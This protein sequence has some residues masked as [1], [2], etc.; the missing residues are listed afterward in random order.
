MKTATVT[1]RQLR[2]AISRIVRID[3]GEIYIRL[4]AWEYSLVSANNLVNERKRMIRALARDI[5]FNLGFGKPS[6]NLERVQKGLPMIIPSRKA[7]AKMLRE[8]SRGPS[9]P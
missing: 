4:G 8:A 6:S 7:L 1:E 3:D 9:A 2:Y 5:F